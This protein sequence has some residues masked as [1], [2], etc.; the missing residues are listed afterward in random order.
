MQHIFLSGINA[1]STKAR[2]GDIFFYVNS[3]IKEVDQESFTGTVVIKFY[4]K[5]P[6][7]IQP[8]YLPERSSCSLS[9]V[10]VEVHSALHSELRPHLVY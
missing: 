6:S 1:V 4:V 5:V 10:E 2:E 3:R 9:V 8:S 7:C